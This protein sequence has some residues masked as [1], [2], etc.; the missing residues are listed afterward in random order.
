MGKTITDP[1]S[2]DQ[3]CFSHGF[4]FPMTDP[5]SRRHHIRHGT[6][7]LLVLFQSN[8]ALDDDDDDDNEDDDDDS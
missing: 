5:A 6:A 2:M 1:W 3:S 8:H 4:G 7:K